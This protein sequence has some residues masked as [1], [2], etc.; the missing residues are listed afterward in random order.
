MTSGWSSVDFC[1][2]DMRWHRCLNGWFWVAIWWQG[3][4]KDSFWESSFQVIWMLK[5]HA[6]RSLREESS[7]PPEP[8]W[9]ESFSLEI[10][11]TEFNRTRLWGGSEVSPAVRS[12]NRLVTSRSPHVYGKVQRKGLQI[13]PTDCTGC[14]FLLVAAFGFPRV[15]I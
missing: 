7:V 13:G 4:E 10:T 2:C 1:L 12:Q 5:F 11:T 14:H 9:P 6:E 3:S 15:Y 8:G